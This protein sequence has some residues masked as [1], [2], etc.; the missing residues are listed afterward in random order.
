MVKVVFLVQ[1]ISGGQ[2]GYKLDESSTL[3]ALGTGGGV[4]LF[5]SS[6][7]LLSGDVLNNWFA[8]FEVSGNTTRRARQS[9]RAKLRAIASSAVNFTVFTGGMI[10]KG[11][12][13][14][15]ICA[16]ETC[17]VPALA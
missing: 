10:G 11:K 15:A 5:A 12:A 7:D 9:G 17:C 2:R 14:L 16:L 3:A 8:G 6:T 13:L 4:D 1:M